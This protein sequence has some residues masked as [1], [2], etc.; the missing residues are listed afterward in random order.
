MHAVFESISSLFQDPRFAAAWFDALIKSFV[1]L[2]FAGGVCLV[3]RRA[4]AATRHLIWFLALTSLPLLPLL[5]HVLPTAHHPL[6]S[7]SSEL[8]SGNQI[9]LSLELTPN[10]SAVNNAEPAAQQNPSSLPVAKAVKHVLNAHF[11]QNWLAIAF[12]AW[13]V[14]M[15]LMALYSTLGRLQLRKISRGAHTLDKPE[16][17][18]LLAQARAALHLRQRVVLLQ[19]DEN[20]MPVTWGWLRGKVLMPLEAEHWTEDRRRI[21]LM[22]ELAHV[23]RLDC[24]TQTIARIITAL[25]WF[26][27][28][29]WMAARQMCIERE[30]ACDD[31]VLNGG[32]KASDYAGHLVQIAKAFRRAPQMAGIAMARSSNLEGRVTAIIDPSRARRLRPI[33]LIAVLIATA[34]VIFCIGGY[35]TSFAN[36]GDSSLRQQQIS[37]LKEFSKQQLEH[38]KILAAS[39]GE[40]IIP[41]YQHLFDAAI[42]GD[43]QAVTNMYWQVFQI[44]H[45]Q[46]DRKKSIEKG[47][48]QDVRFHNPAWGDVLDTCLAYNNFADCNPR[49]TQIYA[50]GIIDSIPP[51]S[52]YFGGTDPGRGVPTEFSKSHADADPFYI[53]T[54]N[55]LADGTYLDYLRNMYGERRQWLG[56]L[57]EAHQNDL[58]LQKLDRD[59][60]NALEKEASLMSQN[61]ILTFD[62]PRCQAADKTVEDLRTNRN[63]R[64]DELLAKAQAQMDPQKKA[65]L[66]SQLPQTIYIPTA[67]DS[68]KAFDD[69]SADALRRL[70]HDEKFPKEPRQVKPGENVTKGEDGKIK[71]RGEIAV[72]SINGLL[73]K[74]IFDKNPDREFYIEESFPLVWTFPHLEPHGL[75][76]KINREP[77]AQLPE[78]VVQRDHDY[79]QKVVGGMIGDWLTDDTPVKTVTEFA[80]R[81]YLHKD[82]KGFTG[83]PQF[84]QNDCAQKMFSKLR[85]SIGGVYS[86]RIGQPPSGGVTP[87]EYVVTGAERARMSKA[88]DFAFKQSFAICPYSPEAVY[89]YVQ[90]LVNERRLPDALLIAETAA[91]IDPANGQ[92]PYLIRNLKQL[93]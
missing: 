5:P 22:H 26:N 62:D 3:W 86:W 65:Q 17:T 12:G 29:A 67:A 13:V 47:I 72:M 23:K 18:R 52:I 50:D 4:A 64:A 24:L 79:W 68:Q 41:E 90:F 88:T 8:V 58:E 11:R 25:Y 84:V 20:I 69:Y 80:E 53:L 55:A 42:A 16:W 73:C 9:S 15:V 34:V 82:L 44:R 91:R 1:V 51:G 33:G 61:H 40:P 37:R 77:L 45:P 54:Q 27:P 35:Q 78:E 14:G 81:V 75:I 57:T 60:Q 59:F 63:Q 85:S 31:L 30:R 93:Q 92:F 39:S 10:K 46:Y 76:M 74:I 6:W 21:V 89:R 48:P 7:V 36:D 38:S 87:R 70:E 49:Y 66:L 32:C 83:D 28:L 56:V 2:G 71:V 43:V 19:S